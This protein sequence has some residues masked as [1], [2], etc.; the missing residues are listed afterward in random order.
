MFEVIVQAILVLMVLLLTILYFY[1]RR[2]YDYWKDR[3]IPY[4]KPTFLVGNLGRLLRISMFDFMLNLTKKHKT[5]YFGIFLGWKPV[6]VINSR[7]L[8]KKVLVKD[9]EHFQNR[10]SFPGHADDPLGAL[11]LFTVKNP[12]WGTMRN[13]LAPMF[14]SSRLKKLAELMNINSGELVRR[15]QADYIDNNKP[16]DMKELFS[17]YT[18]DTVAYTVFGLRVSVLKDLT[19]PLW[20]ITQH[21]V[22]W[23]FWRGF[24]F[25]MIFFVPAVAAI[26]KLKFFSEPA[27]NY[28]K[29]LFWDVVEERKKTNNPSNQ[30]LLHLML[31]LKENLKLPVGSD[32]ELADNLMLAQAAVFILG[33]IE[34][35]STTLSYC[36]HELAYHPQVQEKL[37][38][39]VSEA[40]EQTGKDILEFNDLLELRYLTACVKETLRKFPTLAFLDRVCNRTYQ[41]TDDV[42]IEKGTPVYINVHAIQRNEKYYPEPEEWK[43]ERFVDSS[44]DN[45]NHDFTFL[46]FGEGPRFCIGKRYGMLQVRAAIAQ[47]VMK[48]RFEPKDPYNVETDPYSVILG[49]K[50]GGKIKFVLR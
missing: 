45:D 50:G 5:D 27:T 49:P 44:T 42:T 24:E 3:G 6:L 38:K 13:E 21:M 37:Y 20:F 32:K 46:P 4:E 40:M 1:L 47:M 22:R 26:M 34:T 33:S 12:M 15:I 18:S 31:Q 35:S 28:V 9:F 25:S 30:D 17:M 29:K 16:V 11:N 19:S 10:Y 7:K 39:E 41:L 2:Q 14:T 48:Y 8:A 36:L 43:P 23:T